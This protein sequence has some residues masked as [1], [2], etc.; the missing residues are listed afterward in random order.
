MSKWLERARAGKPPGQDGVPIVPIVPKPQLGGSFGTI[1]TIGTGIGDIESLPEQPQANAKFRVLARPHNDPEDWMAAFEE[2]AGILEFDGGLPRQ[3]A[4]HQAFAD[5]KA[6]LGP[7][8]RE[9]R[10][11]LFRRNG[12]LDFNHAESKQEMRNRLR[13]WKGPVAVPVREPVLPPAVYRAAY[14]DLCATCPAG[15]PEPRWRQAIAD[16]ERFLTEWGELA[17]RLGWTAD[18][19][20]GLHPTVPLSRMD[21]MGL[22]GLL[23][24]QRVVL[25]TATEARFEGGL[26]YRRP[27]RARS[28]P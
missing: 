25:L 8:P 17:E 5:I 14:A 1:G 22:L 23:K 11:A 15:V 18:D 3:Q 16:A 2:R 7:P 6:Q 26:T 9:V 13:A 20:F 10:D 12:T 21:H 24:G 4:E 19:L 28:A 27:A